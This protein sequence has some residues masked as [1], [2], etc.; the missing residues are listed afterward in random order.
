MA[1]LNWPVI[2]H[3]RRRK[4][5]ILGRYARLFSPSQR[6]R[7][8]RMNVQNVFLVLPSFPHRFVFFSCFFFF[9]VDA[10]VGVNRKK[11]PNLGRLL[12]R[13]LSLCVVQGKNTRESRT[14]KASDSALQPF[15]LRFSLARRRTRERRKSLR[16][17]ARQS[18]PL[19]KLVYPCCCFAL[20]P[21]IF[22]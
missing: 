22:L 2:D 1:F 17:S 15:S 3:R 19:E 11:T 16:K 13:S 20:F 6:R 18:S 12:A 14:E 7:R 10:A 4:E 8:F 9:V 21:E 5:T